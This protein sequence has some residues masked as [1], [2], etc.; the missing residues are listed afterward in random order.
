MENKWADKINNNL[1]LNCVFKSAGYTINIFFYVK[2][3]ILISKTDQS[4]K[5]QISSDILRTL[6]FFLSLDF[7]TNEVHFGNRWCH[8]W[9]WKRNHCQQRWDNPQIMW[10]T[11]HFH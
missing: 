5:Q 9:D 3:Y 8:L 4:Q 7:E 2:R 11:R 10:I 1:K 6:T